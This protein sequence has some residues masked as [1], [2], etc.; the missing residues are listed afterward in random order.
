[1]QSQ[2]EIGGES[3]GYWFFAKELREG[4]GFVISGR[5]PLYTLYL[6]LFYWLEYPY[7]VSVEWFFTSL[8]TSFS[9]YLLLN[10]KLSRVYSIIAVILWLPFIRYC[11]PPVQ[12]LALATSC[13]AFVLRSK[14]STS[15]DVDTR[16]L[17]SISYALLIMAYM[18]RVTYILLLFAVLFYDIWTIYKSSRIKEFLLSVKIVKSDLLLIVVLIFFIELEINAN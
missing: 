15:R 12:S 5:S 2:Y 6:Q 14:I 1:M 10:L 18:F 17:L 4:S 9:L 7:N 3:W 11:E 13:I 8:I 16:V